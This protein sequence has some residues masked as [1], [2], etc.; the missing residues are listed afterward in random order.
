VG[1]SVGKEVG[2]D[3]NVILQTSHG[4]RTI[5]MLKDLDPSKANWECELHFD[6][7]KVLKA[8]EL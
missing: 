1:K 7:W 2:V 4:R 3:P 5:D 6:L 8:R